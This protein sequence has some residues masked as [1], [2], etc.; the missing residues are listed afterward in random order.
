MNPR[1]RL[2]EY[3]R[4][5]SFPEYSSMP[6]LAAALLALVPL[7]PLFA[8]DSPTWPQFGGPTGDFRTA[9]KAPDKLAPAAIK[10]RAPI[11]LGESS[12]V[13]DGTRLYTMTGTSDET[14]RTKG[15]ESVIALDPKDGSR[16][17][18]HKYAV[19][20]LPK[21]DTPVKGGR[22]GPQASPCVVGG[23][24]IAIGYTGRVT[25][26]D[27][28]TGKVLW[29]KELE[30][31]FGG[32]RPEFGFASSPVPLDKLVLI[33]VGGKQT[34][35]VALDPAD[36]S[37]KWR[38]AAERASCATPQ[39]ATVCG[40]RQIVHL[41]RNVLHGYSI[42]DGK[43]LWAYKLPV[44]GLTNVPSPL[45]LAD[46]RVVISGQGVNGMRLLKVA[47]A[48]DAYEVK[49]VWK[50]APQFFYCVWGVIGD[51]LYGSA[52]DD[53]VTVNLADGEVQR[54][55]TGLKDANLVLADGAPL[56]LR[57]DGHL[58]R[59]KFTDGAADAVFDLPV[60]AART[61]TPPTVVGDT[62]YVRNT[63]EVVAVSL[64]G[65]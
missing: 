19:I 23:R 26:L 7:A 47:K 28:A 1:R 41:S 32:E 51:R 27:A 16:I 53:F 44:Q 56:V 5:L 33:P 12:V 31:D 14:D 13:G 57:K 64:A 29:E 6:R 54:T 24:V 63:T 39:V 9:A 11:S 34:A 43:E 42:A 21:G 10:W 65:K 30:K 36:G 48:G 18:E 59:F 60:T 52:K 8:A 22:C 38:T 62:L 17:W 35:L 45:V 37:E 46:D 40:V 61:W 55:G 25:A 2:C 20:G 4:I 50:A 3:L 58:V 49:E 15:T